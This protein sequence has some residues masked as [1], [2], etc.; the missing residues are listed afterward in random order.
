ML[1][2]GK[3]G[4]EGVGGRLVAI[5]GL[6]LG[7][8]VAVDGRV[9]SGRLVSITSVAMVPLHEWIVHV[10]TQQRVIQAICASLRLRVGRVDGTQG[11]SGVEWD[12]RTQ[13]WRRSDVTVGHVIHSQVTVLLTAA[14]PTAPALSEVPAHE[15]LY[16]SRMD[17]PVIPLPVFTSPGLNETIVQRQIVTNAISP[18]LSFIYVIRVVLFNPIID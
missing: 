4:V 7:R 9:T 3:R 10:L 5:S 14:T 17:S 12:R 8:W 2:R 16:V 18:S 6:P 1:P 13:G 11:W 15:V